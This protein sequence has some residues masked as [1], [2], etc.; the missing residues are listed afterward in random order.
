M[1]RQ[2]AEK[3]CEVLAFLPNIVY[4]QR[5]VVGIFKQ[6][7]QHIVAGDFPYGVALGYITQSRCSVATHVQTVGGRIVT[8]MLPTEDL[9]TVAWQGNCI[10]QKTKHCASTDCKAML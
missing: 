8:Y 1:L 2:E 7:L 10:P 3:V 4:R 6:L 5:V 9:N